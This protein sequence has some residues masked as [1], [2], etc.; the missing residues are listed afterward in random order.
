MNLPIING[1]SYICILKC[2]GDTGHPCLMPWSDLQLG[3]HPVFTQIVVSSYITSVFLIDD[4]KF[5]F[6]EKIY[7]S[8]S[9]YEN[10]YLI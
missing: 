8:M 7:K 5:R 10:K 2:V 4:P 9:K 6:V 1:C 3:I